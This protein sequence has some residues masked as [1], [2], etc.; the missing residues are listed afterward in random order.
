MSWTGGSPGIRKTTSMSEK[1][2]RLNEVNGWMRRKKEGMFEELASM[3]TTRPWQPPST[4]RRSAFRRL[5]LAVG[6]DVALWR[7]SYPS[8]L[9]SKPRLT[10]LQQ[11]FTP[12]GQYPLSLL[13]IRFVN[14]HLPQVSDLYAFGQTDWQLTLSM[15]ERHGHGQNGSSAS[16]SRTHCVRNP[17][18]SQS[19][20]RDWVT[21]QTV[22]RYQDA[23]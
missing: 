22:S 21:Y 19:L 6:G 9:P 4:T 18:I 8:H 14:A 7:I 2:S 23:T 17:R 20:C 5:T 15:T 11:P 3:L 12:V 1:M 16:R 10:S 13:I